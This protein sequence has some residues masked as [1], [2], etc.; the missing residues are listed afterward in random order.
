MHPIKLLNRQPR[1]VV[2]EE[3]SVEGPVGVGGHHAVAVRARRQRRA[4][5]VHVVQCRGLVGLE[6][7]YLHLPLRET[8]D[9]LVGSSL[10]PRHARDRRR[11]RKLVADAL[12]LPA[13]GQSEGGEHGGGGE[14]GRRC[15]L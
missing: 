9:D 1:T 13:V 14:G 10:W 3:K 8:E 2:V 4:E 11:L 15:V 6:L 7:A 12:T 5:A